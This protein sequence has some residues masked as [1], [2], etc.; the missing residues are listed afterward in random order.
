MPVEG[1]VTIRPTET[2]GQERMTYDIITLVLADKL[3]SCHD[4]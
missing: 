3:V 4:F 2:G 1:I